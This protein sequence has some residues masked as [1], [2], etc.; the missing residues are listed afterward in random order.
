MEQWTRLII[1]Q[2][3]T[4]TDYVNVIDSCM[5]IINPKLG[6]RNAVWMT[7]YMLSMQTEY[8]ILSSQ[9]LRHNFDFANNCPS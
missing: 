6:R 5:A 8:A 4:M 3:K 7:T 9:W 2:N 1:F